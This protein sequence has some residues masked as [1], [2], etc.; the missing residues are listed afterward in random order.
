MHLVKRDSLTVAKV[1]EMY[2]DARLRRQ[3][4][5]SLGLA[6]RAIQNVVPDSGLS[7]REL[8]EVIA[9]SAIARRADLA[10]DSA[11]DPLL[12]G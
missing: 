7:E 2:L 6:A 10:F 11:D 8:R 4:P 5:I 9:V 12:G 3:R 1:I